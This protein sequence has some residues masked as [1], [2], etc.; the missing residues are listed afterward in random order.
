MNIAE[1][2]RMRVMLAGEQDLVVVNS[3]AVTGEALSQTR[4][5]FRRA[6]RDH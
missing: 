4:K 5:A 6:R 3:C 2:E 1:A